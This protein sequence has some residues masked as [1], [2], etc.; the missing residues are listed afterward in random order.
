MNILKFNLFNSKIE[1]IF[2]LIVILFYYLNN[3]IKIITFYIFWYP[4]YSW[5]IF[6][7]LILEIKTN[8]KMPK[9]K[10]IYKIK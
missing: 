6:G 7:K 1:I 10:L 8:A 9:L 5:D 4:I 3:I 2:I